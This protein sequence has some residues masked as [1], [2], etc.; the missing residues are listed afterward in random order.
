MKNDE[1]KPEATLADVSE[2]I[3]RLIEGTEPLETALALWRECHGLR[4]TDVSER[5]G[6]RPSA[7]SSMLHDPDRVPR[8][9]RDVAR[10][11]GYQERPAAPEPPEAA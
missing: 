11:I 8:V 7:V 9:R 6:R 1:P 2:I 4:L 10:L 5:I 3:R